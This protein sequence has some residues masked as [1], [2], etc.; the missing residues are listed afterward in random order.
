MERKNTILLTVIAVATLLVAVVGA[1]FAYFTATSDVTATSTVEVTTSAASS[2]TSTATNCTLNVQGTDMLVANGTAAGAVAKSTTCTIAITGT[3][4]QSSTT[5]EVC[6][7]NLKYTPTS[8]LTDKSA[9]ALTG[10]KIEVRLS[11][12]V[13][14]DSD[15]ASTGGST[16]FSNFDL[17]NVETATNLLANSS[18]FTYGGPTSANAD[19]VS[20]A[21]WTFT[22]EF[23]NYNFDQ[24]LLAG[25]QFGGSISVDSFNC[26][27]AAA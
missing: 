12:T 16:S 3:H 8:A 7:Y 23:L 9:D 18:T 26:Q 22:L 10:N 11:G 2:V 14:D 15:Y 4:P 1:T 24:N 17:Y 25:K 19:T 13:A 5:N 21:T 6:T 20:T 27:A